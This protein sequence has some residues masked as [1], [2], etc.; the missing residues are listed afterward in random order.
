M[1]FLFIHGWNGFCL[2]EWSLRHALEASCSEP[3]EFR[4]LDLTPNNFA[5]HER[6][7]Q[8]LAMYSPDVV[9]LSCHFWNLAGY[10]NLCVAVK[11][12]LPNARVVLGGPQVSSRRAAEAIL[13]QHQAVDFIIRGDGERPLCRLFEAIAGR[14]SWSSIR[15]LSRH[16][17]NV[18]D[19]AEPD[20]CGEWRGTPLF[21]VGNRPLSET[22]TRQFVVSYETM[23]G[24]RFRCGYCK[25]PT[26]ATTFLGDALVASELEYLC[27]FGIPHVR[28]CDAHFGGNAA[29]AKFLLR[30]L[31]QVN[32]CSSIK[33][34]PDIGHIDEE[35]L[36]LAEAAGVE[37]TSIGI[38]TT[39]AA[40]LRA[41]GRPAIHRR[42]RRIRMVLERFPDTPADLIVGLP[43]D[44]TD[45]LRKTC[46]D[47][48]DLGFNQ[49]NFNRLA[50]FPGSPFGEETEAYF[51]AVACL[52]ES[53]QLI[54]SEFLPPDTQARTMSLTTALKIAAIFRETRSLLESVAVDRSLMDLADR[55]DGE[56]LLLLHDR[57]FEAPPEQV[58]HDV[59][60]I[61]S[62][63]G[64]ILS[65]DPRF[66]E[67][68]TADVL[69][70]LYRMCLQRNIVALS[71]AQGASRRRYSRVRCCLGRGDEILWDLGR[72]SFSQSAR[73]DAPDRAEDAQ[74]LVF[75]ERRP[76]LVSPRIH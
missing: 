7:F 20:D 8:L 48:L 23:R 25:Y 58:L 3:V 42:A 71:I 51:N 45:G 14:G 18:I 64:P 24:C 69:F 15:G 38:Q 47:V 57:L 35:Y 27:S 33:I 4:S 62:C 76:S 10:L 72:R 59:P 55:L 32:Q 11:Q 68:V 2:A 1:R 70:H 60:L 21:D 49:I 29:R 41:S 13:K 61:W 46:R 31:A 73:H 54:R 40:A 39:N 17:D 53:G 50:L 37:F 67:T 16:L 75:G 52:A 66:E 65:D 26:N 30:V 43:R 63:L 28:I 12:L 74:T 5:E 36:G 22:L 34:Y 56:E 9:G 44:T 19:H 6:F